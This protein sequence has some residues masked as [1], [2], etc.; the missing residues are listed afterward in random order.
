MKKLRCSGGPHK[1]P[2]KS[3][4]HRLAKTQAK[5]ERRYVR[6][7]KLLAKEMQRLE[8]Y[9]DE[10]KTLVPE[11]TDMQELIRAKP[12]LASLGLKVLGLQK[13]LERN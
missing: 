4:A 3:L 9:I 10:A 12:V 2:G 8:I 11:A 13:W 7:Q 5:K 1:C 6:K